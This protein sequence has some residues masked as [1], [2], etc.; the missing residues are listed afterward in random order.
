MARSRPG[1]TIF[2]R[3][4]NPAGKQATSRIRLTEG[5]P[6]KQPKPVL[7]VLPDHRARP[8]SCCYQMLPIMVDHKG[9]SAGP[10]DPLSCNL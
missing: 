9:P 10:N 2:V 4:M 7:R 3:W 1:H 6:Q 8:A 5:P